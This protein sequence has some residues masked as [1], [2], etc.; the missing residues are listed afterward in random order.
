MRIRY[1][2]SMVCLVMLA[3][4]GIG[5]AV[6]DCMNMWP[7]SS[8]L[9]NCLTCTSSGPVPGNENGSCGYQITVDGL[10]AFCYCS[11]AYNCLS[12]IPT[13][14]DT[15]MNFSGTCV[16]GACINV[17]YLGSNYGWL[18]RKYARLCPPPA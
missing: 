5:V 11:T 8:S 3:S 2:R 4:I 10:Q 16:G 13:Q 1:V 9:P 15:L 14:G 6:T 17:L 12:S 18:T 7:S